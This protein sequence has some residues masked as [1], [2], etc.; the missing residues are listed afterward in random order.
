[1]SQE[2][3]DSFLLIKEIVQEIDKLVMNEDITETKKVEMLRE[4]L[5]LE[6]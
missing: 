2:Y 4:L 3:T 1:M 5:T 6:Y